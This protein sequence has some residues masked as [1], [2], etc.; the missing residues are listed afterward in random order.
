MVILHH[1]ITPSDSFASVL[2]GT[3]NT[4]SIFLELSSYWI[5]RNS[6]EFYLILGGKLSS[7]AVM[8][9]NSF[10]AQLCFMIET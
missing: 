1:Y 3:F 6:L 5:G 8:M 2:R 4:S 9:N 7:L 10:N